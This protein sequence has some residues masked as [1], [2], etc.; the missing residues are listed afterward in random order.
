MIQESVVVVSLAH[1]YL[2]GKNHYTRIK[3][4]IRF[5]K[6]SQLR[7]PQRRAKLVTGACDPT[8]VAPLAAPASPNSSD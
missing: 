5:V 2:Q 7:R 8:G 4:C 6:P 1:V 3:H